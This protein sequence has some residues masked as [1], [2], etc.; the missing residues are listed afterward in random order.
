MFRLTY[1]TM[2]DPPED[3]HRHFDEAVASVRRTLEV[4]HVMATGGEDVRAPAQYAVH[5]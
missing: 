1:S 2:F 5:A 3:L 4:E